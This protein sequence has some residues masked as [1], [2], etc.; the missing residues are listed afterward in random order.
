MKRA[1]IAIRLVEERA[2][3][4]YTAADFARKVGITREGLRLYE[5]GQRGV[6]AEFLAEAASLGVDVQYVLTGVRSSNV[7]QAEQAAAEGSA[8][9]ATIS[10]HASA[11]I[12]Q[13]PQAGATITQIT[14]QKHLTTTKA[15]VKPG[16][17][18]VSES[19]AARLTGLVKQVVEHEEKLRRQPRTYRSVWAALNAHCGV[20]RYRLIPASDFP[21][22]EKYLLQWIGRLNSMAS[23]PVADNDA[24]RKRKFAYIKI[25]TK[26]DE[27]WLARY[28]AK[29]YQAESIADLTDTQLDRVYQA[30]ARR[31]RSRE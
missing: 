16:T 8:P 13:F 4:R 10:G 1:D 22:A 2:R 23:A 3:I 29:N 20:T 24:W 7:T 26:D 12:V 17:E 18:H 19:Q 21:K 15:E 25:N 9:L 28:I 5:A 6:S 11:N 30:V 14:T 27:A 31:K